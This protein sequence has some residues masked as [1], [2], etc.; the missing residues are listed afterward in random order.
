MPRPGRGPGN[1]EKS[2]DFKGSM[3]RLI[4]NLSP[5]K[6][7][8][9]MALGLAMVS[10][11]LALIAP[12]K[13]S[14]FADLIGEGLVPNTEVLEEVSKKIENNLDSTGKMAV[15]TCLGYGD[16]KIDSTMQETACK[17]LSNILVDIEVDG[18]TIPV[19]DQIEMLKLS[20]Q[21]GEEIQTEKALG[22]MEKLPKSIYGLVKPKMNM[23]AIKNL[24][25]FMG[26]LYLVSALFNY[27]QSYSLTTVSNRFANK[28]RDNISKK[29]NRLPLKYFDSH[30]TGDVLSR[31]TND[32]DTVAFNLNNSLA[33]IVTS[34]TLFLGSLFMMFIT[35]WILAI[36]AILSCLIGFVLMFT[37]LSKSQKYFIARQ[38][39]L[40][41]MNGYIEEMYSGHNVVK[42]YNGTK[43]AF[44]EFDKL[45]KRMYET[46]RKSQF[47]SGLMHP[48]MGFIGNLGY[49]AVC[50]VGALLTMNNVISFG[51]IVAF[52]IYVRMFSNPLNQIA[53]AMSSLQS[54]AAASERVFE[55][56]DEK[57]MPLQTHISKRLNKVKAK[58]EIEFKNVKFGYDTGKTIIKDFSVK[59]KPGQ[60]IA[61]VGPT[62]AGK[63]TMVNLL[64]K[65][66]D[67]NSGQIIIDGYDTNEL[68]RENVHD[69]FIMVLQ[70]TWL[71]EGTIRDNIKFTKEDVSDREIW[72]ALKTVGVHHFVKTLPG[73]LD[74]VIGDNDS[75]SQG[76]K[77]LLTIARGMIEDAPFLILDEATSNVDTRT[78][79]LVQK[80]MD[81]LTE[82]RTSFIIAHRLSTIRNADIILVMNEG[83]IIE[84]GTHEELMKQKGFYEKLYN[85]QF[86]KTM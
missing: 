2:K 21:M 31:V 26:C 76:Q 50:I 51:V 79:E 37:I 62:G 47:L 18:V 27:I 68:T 74:Y 70:D 53:Q 5:W 71:F 39:A 58:G 3:L 10:A 23:D 78:E 1:F 60:K 28:L 4:K 9:C 72:E 77:Q 35:N 86:E 57:E 11:I 64:M 43:E 81:K 6:F 33:T 34:V 48:I 75:I 61:I 14:D 13:L 83:N 29:I 65:F 30:E 12:N 52:M 49:V 59:V 20:A 54:T 55:F 15:A 45:N 42:A 66:Y 40:G 67:I 63:T 8:M 19:V 7:I 25:I 73:G 17:S 38:E 32:V 84:Q 82:G 24:A 36:T 16:I 46:N 44:K 69:L 80:A 56:L 22:L 85:S 41:D